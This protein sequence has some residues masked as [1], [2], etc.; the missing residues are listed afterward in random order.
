MKNNELTPA[1]NQ[2]KKAGDDAVY[3][4]DS[5]FPSEKLNVDHISIATTTVS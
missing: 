3:K 4:K 2:F 5:G 1:L